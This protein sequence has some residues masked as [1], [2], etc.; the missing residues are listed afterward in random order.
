MSGAALLLAM[1]GAIVAYLRQDATLIV[2]ATVLGLA[3]AARMPHR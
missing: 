3:A 2:A 1:A